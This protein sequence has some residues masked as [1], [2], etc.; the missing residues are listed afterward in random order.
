MGQYRVLYATLYCLLFL[1][2]LLCLV[3]DAETYG[4]PANL[5]P[6]N[7]ANGGAYRRGKKNENR[8]SVGYGT[9]RGVVSRCREK[10]LRC[11]VLRIK[12]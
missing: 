6:A 5:H 2:V 7:N 4:D 10:S 3:N 9:C 11:E 12:S 8:T 1:R